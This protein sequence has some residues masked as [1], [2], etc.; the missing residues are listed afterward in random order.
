MAICAA[1]TPMYGL[2]GTTLTRWC[3]C[4]W[5]QGQRLPK[6]PNDDFFGLSS[7]GNASTKEVC[8]KVL[9]GVSRCEG[10]CR[11]VGCYTRRRGC[12]PLHR[13]RPSSERLH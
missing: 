9:A 6:Q 8:V 5:L 10:A 4:A 1:L 7:L 12:S 2:D 11:C 3:G 13:P